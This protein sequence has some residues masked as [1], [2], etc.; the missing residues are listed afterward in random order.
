M[1]SDMHHCNL[2][3]TTPRGHSV[4]F[5]SVDVLSEKHDAVMTERQSIMATEKD[6]GLLAL[7]LEMK[8]CVSCEQT[9][10]KSDFYKRAG[11]GVHS[12]CKQCCRANAKKIKRQ[13]K[14]KAVRKDLCY[15]IVVAAL[16]KEGIPSIANVMHIDVLAWGLVRICTKRLTADEATGHRISF[17]LKQR[18]EGIIADIIA[19]VDDDNTLYFFQA[20]DPHFYLDGQLK[21]SVTFGTSVCGNATNSITLEYAHRHENWFSLVNETCDE[22]SGRLSR[23][24]L[25]MN[26]HLGR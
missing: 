17:T 10:P 9:L 7:T 1:C 5:Q 12:W 19:I 21:S 13:G 22:L 26:S 20:N 14:P 15:G 6:E 25:D 11:K 16:S 3:H 18:T 23:G 2:D 8:Q 4:P 24:E